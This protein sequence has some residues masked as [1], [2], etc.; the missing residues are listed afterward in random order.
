MRFVVGGNCFS[1]KRSREAVGGQL[2][3]SSEDKLM[4]TRQGNEC[5]LV[6]VVK[7]FFF[8]LHLQLALFSVR[9]YFLLLVS[10][11]CIS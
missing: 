4:S 9:F 8:F 11:R 6:S 1:S 3:R 2:K 10:S 5:G 7:E